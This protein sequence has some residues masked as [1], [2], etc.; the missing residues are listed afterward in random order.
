MINWKKVGTQTP[1]YSE[2][3]PGSRDAP[4]VRCIVWAC[5]P[6][7]ILGGTAHTVR[8]NTKNNCWHE[9]DMTNWLLQPPYEITHF[10]DDINM[11][12]H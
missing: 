9:P 12:S 1:K 10:C 5:N 3:Y 8:W 6:K 7:F 4:F 2:K 11:P